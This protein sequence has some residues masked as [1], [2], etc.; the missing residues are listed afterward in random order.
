MNEK[1]AVLKR[2][3]MLLVVFIAAAGLFRMF[4]LGM[5]LDSHEGSIASSVRVIDSGGTLYKDVFDPNPPFPA[6]LYRLGFELSGTSDRALRIFSFGYFAFTFILIYMA[7]RVVWG[8]SAAVFSA[9]LYLLLQNNPALG[10]L[11]ASAQFLG[12]FPLVLAFLF[13]FDTDEEYEKVNYFLAGFF[14]AVA[15]LC[16]YGYAA[17]FPAAVIAALIFSKKEKALK[18]TLVCFSGFAVMYL[19]AVLWSVV[20]GNTEGFGKTFLWTLS[21]LKHHTWQGYGAVFAANSVLFLKLSLPAAAGAIYAF[22]HREKDS[23]NN[24]A[25]VLSFAFLSLFYYIYILKGVELRYYQ[26]L[27][28]AAALLGG[29]LLSAVFRLVSDKSRSPLAAGITA[30]IIFA[31]CAA[32][33][34]AVSKPGEYMKKGGY[35]TSEYSEVRNASALAGFRKAKGD[36]LLAW[37]DMAQAYFYTG[38]MPHRRHMS[39]VTYRYFPQES[40]EI[41]PPVAEGYY[42]FIMLRGG[43]AADFIL[44]II[45][46]KYTVVS[47]SGGIM[48]YKK[49]TVQE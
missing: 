41:L 12:H 2:E 49:N 29:I 35:H 38:M 31:A 20:Q 23:R 4:F 5:P 47:D 18:N 26:S 8:R 44:R 39:A 27:I 46:G 21:H 10:S 13:L 24:A 14:T 28:P 25:A 45:E 1:D 19:L 6:Y 16:W 48:V 37:P 33:S 22:F 9:L 36:T 30:V 42:D 15:A 34:L 11:N 3:I 43:P 32:C 17:V 7:A 40:T